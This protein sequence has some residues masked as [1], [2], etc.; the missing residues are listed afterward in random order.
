MLLS[1]SRLRYSEGNSTLYLNKTVFKCSYS[2]LKHC[3]INRENIFSKYNGEYQTLDKWYMELSGC[4]FY[5][6]SRSQPCR[7][8][9]FP[10]IAVKKDYILSSLNQHRFIFLKFWR[11]EILNGFHWA[12]I[13][14]WTAPDSLQSFWEKICLLAFFSFSRTLHSW[15]M[16]SALFFKASGVDSSLSASIDLGFH[17][18]QGLLIF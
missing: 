13:K 10:M 17:Y 14:V 5:C 15:I 7:V 2:F 3:G 1:L 9:Q 12:E 6:T 11:S 16:A 8:Y 4:L 18:I